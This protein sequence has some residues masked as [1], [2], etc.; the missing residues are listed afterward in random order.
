MYLETADYWTRVRNYFID[1]MLVCSE[2]TI[3]R[4]LTLKF[5]YFQDLSDIADSL[6]SQLETVAALNSGLGGGPL[7]AGLD[8]VDHNFLRLPFA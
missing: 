6:S 4:Q 8:D 3:K 1:Q 7:G 5:V 2:G